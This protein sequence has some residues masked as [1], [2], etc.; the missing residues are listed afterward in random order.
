MIE[1]SA[2]TAAELKELLRKSFMFKYLSFKDMKV[3][4]LAMEKRE[5][6]AGETIIEEGEDGNC[7]FVVESG[8][9]DC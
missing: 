2:E 8:E 7:I 6:K 4:I 1:K 9:L 3:V 5:A